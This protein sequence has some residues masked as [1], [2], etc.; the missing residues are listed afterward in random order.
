MMRA[1]AIGV[2]AMGKR[3]CTALGE[4]RLM[5]LV[6]IHSRLC[7]SSYGPI[8]ERM[9]KP[10]CGKSFPKQSFSTNQLTKA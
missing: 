6:A 3:I 9:P 2:V 10:V 1:V 4:P 7:N 5:K 8:A